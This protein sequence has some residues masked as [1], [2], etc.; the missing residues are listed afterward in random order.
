MK[1]GTIDTDQQS[2]TIGIHLQ[3]GG[4]FPNSPYP[5]GRSAECHSSLDAFWGSKAGICAAILPP[6][7]FV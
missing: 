3:P 5:A 6:D 1:V 2:C 7:H 4:A